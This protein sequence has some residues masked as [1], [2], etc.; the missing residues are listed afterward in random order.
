MIVLVLLLVLLLLG[1]GFTLHA[2]WIAAAV[3][4]VFWILGF[5]RHHRNGGGRHY[6]WNRR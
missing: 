5:S 6:A 3:L 4:L 2:L 1:A